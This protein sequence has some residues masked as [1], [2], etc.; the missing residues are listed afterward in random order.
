MIDSPPGYSK[1]CYKRVACESGLLYMAR[2]A[3]TCTVRAHFVFIKYKCS[4]NFNQRTYVRK[5][6]VPKSNTGCMRMVLCRMVL[7]AKH[8]PAVYKS[9][10]RDVRGFIHDDLVCMYVSNII[11]YSGY[12]NNVCILENSSREQTEVP[13][14]KGM[15]RA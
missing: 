7:T 4:M 10:L 6:Y 11:M 12:N 5:M 14:N 9:G 3:A 15:G 2:G 13:R 1:Q 8:C